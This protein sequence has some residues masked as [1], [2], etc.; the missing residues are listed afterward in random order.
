MNIAGWLGAWPHG[1]T[2]EHSGGDTGQGG[3][4]GVGAGADRAPGGGKSRN[5]FKS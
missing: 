1:G 2:L 5:Y 4:G 3:V